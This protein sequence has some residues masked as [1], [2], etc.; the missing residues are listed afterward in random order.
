MKK[1][2][3][4]VNF[5]EDKYSKDVAIAAEN[6]L[7]KYGCD[8]MY[9]SHL[10]LL[11][12]RRGVA[13][14]KLYR[15]NTIHLD[16][17]HPPYLVNN[18]AS[19][20]LIDEARLMFFRSTDRVFLENKSLRYFENYFELLVDYWA[21][22]LICNHI[23]IVLFDATPH[24][25]W[26]IPL[27]Y[28]SK[29][30]GI[31]TL[32][33]RRTFYSDAVTICDDFRSGQTKIF[34]VPVHSRFDIKTPN[35]VSLVDRWA[36][37]INSESLRNVKNPFVSLRC[38]LRSLVYLIRYKNSV[39]NYFHLSTAQIA[40]RLVKRRLSVSRAIGFYMNNVRAI[41]SGEGY[42]I[43]ALHFRPE[44][45][46]IPEGGIYC[47]QLE[48]IK[49]LR[50][51]LPQNLCLVIKEH[52]RQL[53]DCPPDLRRLHQQEILMY[54]EIIRLPNTKL[55][56]LECDQRLLIS[57][58]LMTA[59]ISGSVVWE[60]LLLGK[61][62]ITFANTWHSE[63]RSSPDVSDVPCL[64]SKIQ[65][66]LSL[67]NEDVLQDIKNFLDSMGEKVTVG[68][69]SE[70]LSSS[71]ELFSRKQLVEKLSSSLV[72]AIRSTPS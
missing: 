5:L 30:M 56:S 9:A 34:S 1:S 65:S 19:R 41:G 68:A 21:A 37:P 23:S 70:N 39:I 53:G 10:S 28:V 14:D 26:D 31:E 61:P 27:F 11:D 22:Y 71:S 12:G 54:K 40:I 45:S 24:F 3:L 20:E 69:R 43:F 4:F 66:L 25:P 6:E 47:G 46:T 42:V 52:P 50:A 2:I 57:N 7:T 67:S 15:P 63:C 44:R 13:I 64:A 49:K 32:I 18:Q 29:S 60:G 17:S 8:V 35:K 51:A 38:I 16:S 55:A 62:G 59:S 48:A 72:E 33:I 58:S 36:A